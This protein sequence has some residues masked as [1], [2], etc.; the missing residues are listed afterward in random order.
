MAIDNLEKR[1][2]VR[3]ENRIKQMLWIWS[4]DLLKMNRHRFQLRVSSKKGAI[5][6]REAQRAILCRERERGEERRREEKEKGKKVA[7]GSL[8][9]TDDC[10]TERPLPTWTSRAEGFA[11]RYCY[12]YLSLPLP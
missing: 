2:S 7:V 1:K 4:G 9:K 11:K 10:L 3:E 6:V 5:V 8:S 12:L